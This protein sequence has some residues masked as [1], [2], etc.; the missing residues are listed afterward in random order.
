VATTRERLIVYLIVVTLAGGVGALGWHAFVSG[1]GDTFHE[2]ASSICT[3][4]LPA[5]AQAPDFQTAIGRSREMRLR[6]SELTP[7]EAGRETFAA[8]LAALKGS[9]DAALRGDLAAVQAYDAS[10]HP[11]VLALDLGDACLY[12]LN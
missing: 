5:I 10:I 1:G 4:G 2:R 8:W 11:H 7:P 12:G 6:L 3:K 9:E